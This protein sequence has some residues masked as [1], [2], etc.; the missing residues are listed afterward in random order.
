MAD[1]SGLIVIWKTYYRWTSY[2]IPEASTQPTKRTHICPPFP[3]PFSAW[4]Q[5]NLTS[6]PPPPLLL[7]SQI[8][9][10]PFLYHIS[11]SL[12]DSEGDFTHLILDDYSNWMRRGNFYLDV[13]SGINRFVFCPMMLFSWFRNR[14]NATEVV[15][16][17]SF[18]I[19]Y[20]L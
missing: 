5:Q 3:H 6:P 8:F 20:W 12:I 4:P 13:S 7:S 14:C 18:C 2:I 11:F 15:I 17:P 1:N 10:P 19:A 9:L 16:R